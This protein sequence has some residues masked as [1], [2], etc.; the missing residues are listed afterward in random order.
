MYKKICF[1]ASNQKGSLLFLNGFF[2][3]AGGGGN[4]RGWFLIIEMIKSVG[5]W[6]VAG[7]KL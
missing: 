5:S 3:E 1:G 4:Q 2:G 7:S 6:T